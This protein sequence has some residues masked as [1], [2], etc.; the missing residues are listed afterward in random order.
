M[1]PPNSK[2]SSR[3]RAKKPMP[4]P[5]PSPGPVAKNELSMVVIGSSIVIDS[6]AT[7]A[8]ITPS[9]TAFH[10][11]ASALRDLA[12]EQRRR[13]A[14]P[15]AQGVRRD[16]SNCGGNVRLKYD[17][18]PNLAWRADSQRLRVRR[19]RLARTARR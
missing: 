2:T 11:G 3:G 6:R 13:D 8:T 7:H 4:F 16:H 1:A 10:A 15:A 9:R 12:E 5:P 14:L 17:R 18:S 19:R